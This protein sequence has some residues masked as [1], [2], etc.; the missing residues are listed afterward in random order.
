[1]QVQL[2][3]LF[4]YEECGIHFFKF[5]NHFCQVWIII[6]HLSLSRGSGICLQEDEYGMFSHWCACHHM[7]YSIFIVYYP[8]A[9]AKPVWYEK[10][11]KTLILT[12]HISCLSDLNI[13]VSLK[14]FVYHTLGISLFFVQIGQIFIQWQLN[15]SNV[16]SRS[17][18]IGLDIET[19]SW[20]WTVN[21]VLPLYALGNHLG[22][23]LEY[24]PFPEVGYHYI[25]SMSLCIFNGTR[26]RWETFF[27]N[28]F[29]G[30]GGIFRITDWTTL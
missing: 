11:H 20:G 8:F 9:F 21:E 26:I 5:F 12:F 7:T 22:R 14:F 28:F 25:F 16:V 19:I 17:I 29:L 1:M 18:N 6:C 13:S 4:Q 27:I 3:V 24:V 23:H 10:I 30:L 2:L 15:S